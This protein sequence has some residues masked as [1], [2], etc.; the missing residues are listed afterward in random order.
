[1]VHITEE[2]IWP[3]C[4]KPSKWLKNRN[5]WRSRERLVCGKKKKNHFRST[6]SWDVS[7]QTY[8]ITLCFRDT[9]WRNGLGDHWKWGLAG[10]WMRNVPYRLRYLNTCFPADGTVFVAFGAFTKGSLAGGSGS[11]RLGLEVSWLSPTNCP[12]SVYWLNAM[13]PDSSR[14]YFPIMMDNVCLCTMNEPFL[15]EVSILV[16]LLL[17]WKKHH[18]Q[19]QRTKEFIL[20]YGC[21]GLGGHGGQEVQQHETRAGSWEMTSSATTSTRQRTN[22]KR[23]KPL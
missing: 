14:S 12:L 3:G 8:I 2:K 13:W 15:P 21:R 18:D 6:Y 16:A 4:W 23:A 1:M 7:S 19:E 20:A 17:L 10:V 11:L 22:W 5:R 9:P